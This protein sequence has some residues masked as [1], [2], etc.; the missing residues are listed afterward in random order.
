MGGQGYGGGTTAGTSGLTTSTGNTESGSSGPVLT[1]AIATGDTTAACKVYSPNTLQW[2]YP[3]SP[4]QY[5][6]FSA[7]VISCLLPSFFNPCTY[8]P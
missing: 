8:T 2:Q 1:T 7:S 3:R 4:M 5:G 6:E